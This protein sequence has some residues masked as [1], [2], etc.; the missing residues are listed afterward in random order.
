MLWSAFRTRL[1]L[2]QLLIV[3]AGAGL[4]W[5]IYDSGLTVNNNASSLVNDRLPELVQIRTLKEQQLRVERLLYEYYADQN[6]DHYLIGYFQAQHQIEQS[7]TDLNRR[8]PESASLSEI[9][10]YQG[11]IQKLAQRLDQTLDQRPVDWD[12]TRTLLN[13]ISELRQQTEPLVKQLE[14]ALNQQAKISLQNTLQSTQS[15]TRYVVLFSLLIVLVALVA[16]VLASRLLTDRAERRRLSAFAERNP[17]PIL[18]VNLK[19]QLLSLNPA[20]AVLARD[21]GVPAQPIN[22]IPDLTQQMGKMLNQGKT[23]YDWEFAL[24]RRYLTARAVMLSDLK[25]VQVHLRDITV[26][27]RAEAEL[28]HRVSHDLLTDLPN[29]HQFELDA[30]LLIEHYPG[31]PLTLGLLNISRFHQVTSQ[32]GF[33]AGDTI[34]RT[35]A[36]RLSRAL[37][38]LSIADRPIVLYRFSGTRFALLLQGDVTQETLAEIATAVEEGFDAPIFADN[39]PASFHLSFDQGFAHYPRHAANSQELLR[40]ADAAVRECAHRPTRSYILF[41]PIMRDQEDHLIA[42]ENELRTA[43]QE[44][45]FLLH[46]Q[47]QQQ[48]ED[49]ALIGAEA[50]LRWN[51]PQRGLLSPADFIDLAEQTGLIVEIGKWVLTQACVQARQWMDQGRDLVISVNLSARQIQDPSFVE[52]VAE[53][54]RI[55]GAPAQRIELEL[56]ESLLMTDLDRAHDTL[57]QLKALNLQLAIDDFGTGYSSLAYLKRL[58]MD[59]LKIDRRFIANLPDDHQDSAIVRAILDLSQH[60]GLKVVAEGVETQAQHDWLQR[61]GCHVLQGFWYSRPMTYSDWTQMAESLARENQQTD[62]PMRCLTKS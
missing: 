26:A 9:V 56:T 42:L 2:V 8:F 1:V 47:P 35:T 23:D 17:D 59:T 4:S 14:Q 45:Q 10:R 29:R 61:A 50:L 19:G 55:T 46:F 43:I 15:A 24:D 51:H 40:C 21:L 41:D 3:L 32:I 36:Q 34:I 16:S 22:L 33:Q 25:Q 57:C 30:Q 13:Q 38:P 18:S 49:D 7:L 31:Q 20:A 58:P 11:D 62:E 28:R 5:Q 37:N 52:T 39:A 27:S 53:I 44:K 54:L 6:R 48:L 60:L 12:L